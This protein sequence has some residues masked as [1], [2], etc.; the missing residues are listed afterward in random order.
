MKNRKMIGIIAIVVGVVLSAALI[1]LN[2]YQNSSVTTIYMTKAPITAGAYITKDDIVNKTITKKYKLDSY[3][4]NPEDIIGKC[5]AVDLVANDIFTEDK[6]SEYAENTDNQFLNIPSGKQAISFSVS[7]GSDSLSNKL[8]VGDIIRIYDYQNKNGGTANNYDSLQFVR[9]ASITSSGYEDVTD[10][11]NDG[12]KSSLASNSSSS[13][14]ESKSYSTITVIVSSEQAKDI[15]KVE[16]G[17]GA[18]I[19]LISRGNDQLAKELLER[20][21]KIIANTKNA[22]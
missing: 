21:D 3:I 16:K 18:Y 17:N 1:L 15:I 6:V 4:T 19:T 13:E 9:V 22:E 12:T 2:I 10:N 20:Q 5:A 14:K 11:G 8:K 7:G